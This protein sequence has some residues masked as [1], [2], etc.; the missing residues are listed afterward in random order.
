MAPRYDVVAHEREGAW[1]VAIVEQDGTTVAE[2]ACKDAAEAR[3]YAS[4]VR[5]H[6]YWLSDERFREYY[7]LGSEAG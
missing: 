3:T 4:T 6:R 2:R 7:G 5:Q 1:W